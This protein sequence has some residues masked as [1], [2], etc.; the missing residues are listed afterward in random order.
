MPHSLD[1]ELQ[2]ALIE[3]RQ[4][5]KDLVE[6][7]SD[8]AW[9]TDT[10]GRFVFVSPRGALGWHADDLSGRDAA[11]FLVDPERVAIFQTRFPAAGEDVEF[12]RADGAT[13]YLSVAATPILARGG[14]WHGARGLCRDITD[15]RTRERDLALVRLRDRLLT[16]IVRVMR[17]ELDPLAAL[18]A[19]ITA[20]G[21][22]LGA[23]GGVILRSAPGGAMAPTAPWG[24]PAEPGAIEAVIALL[25]RQSAAFCVVDG[26]QFAGQTARCQQSI[27]GAIVLWQRAEVA[28]FPDTD[29]A[30][31]ADVADYLGTAIARI[32]SHEHLVALSRN[33]PL[34]A[35][36]NRR[37]F[38]A[39]L[40]RRLAWLERDGTPRGAGEAML[41]A[42]FY[43]DVDNFKL[44]NDR[45][46]HAAGDEAL[47]KI[48]E[49]LRAHGRPGDLIARLGGDEFAMWIDNIGAAR[50]M[51]RGEKL[52]RACAA[53]G[54]LTGDPLRPLSISVGIAVNDPD[55]REAS[56]QLI[57]R[58]DAAMYGAKNRG[59]GQLALAPPAD[60]AA[61]PA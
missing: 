40:E 42:L 50:A 49:I 23:A 20:T 6:I 36:A 30:L 53:L 9:E 18:G 28:C 14:Q 25:R 29:R 61:V 15:A 32:A 60:G 27:E 22:A 10:E 45:V 38:C 1:Q 54:H 58:A 7:S 5:Y 39:E 47:C 3:S 37:G 8:F 31:L 41:G 4:R 55:Q 13:A 46:G 56:A 17:D 21:L 2:Q 44:V 35:L 24:E 26:A 52:R 34:T 43:I 33:D 16:H 11:T 51:E 12:R 48:A 57:A 19:A 59:K